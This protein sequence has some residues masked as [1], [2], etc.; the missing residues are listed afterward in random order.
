MLTRKQ[1]PELQSSFSNDLYDGLLL[2]N[3]LAGR[4]LLEALPTAVLLI[5]ENGVI[6]H[7][8]HHA[9]ALLKRDN[10]KLIGE[11]IRTLIA[12]LGQPFQEGVQITYRARSPS[13]TELE[14]C[15]C[16]AI[17]EELIQDESST[18]CLVILEGEASW[19][20][21]LSER[22]RLMHLAA[23]GEVLPAVLHELKNP[24]AA[25]MT[26]VEVLLEEQLPDSLNSDFHAIL[27]ELRR[28][29]MTMDGVS[30]MGAK[31]ASDRFQAIDLAIGDACR[32]LGKSALDV[33]VDLR[34]EI[35]VMPLLALESSVIR[36]IL[37]N[38]IQNA[39]QACEQ[40]GEVLVQGSI[41]NSKLLLSV[42]D[43]GRGMSPEVLVHCKELFFS[44]KSRG[45]GIGLPL[46]D[47]ICKE[48]GGELIIESHEG[49]GT[50]ITVLI[51]ARSRI[52]IRPAG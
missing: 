32:V 52:S 19:K 11:N 41:H 23:M 10:A 48:A 49:K 26:L 31:L 7:G 14:M 34:H 25:V 35:Q 44:T 6:L 18:K 51:P 33:G 38:L 3:N 27:G 5:D 40:G 22:N 4:K 12:P 17:T 47:R 30:T 46:C 15:Y 24:L 13:G 2:S 39:I 36:A 43:N 21:L 45:S 28:M 9:L 50:K 8:N 37:F 29:R 1:L 20:R 16:S 42:E